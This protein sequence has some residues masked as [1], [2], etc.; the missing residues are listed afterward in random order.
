M[1]IINWKAIKEVT[2]KWRHILCSWMGTYKSY[3]QT[4]FY[5]PSLYCILHFHQRG[6]KDPPPASERPAET[7]G[8]SYHCLAIKVFFKVRYVLFFL[9]TV[10]LALT[11]VR[12]RYSFYV[13]WETERS[14]WPPR[15]PRYRSGRGLDRHCLSSACLSRRSVVPCQNPSETLW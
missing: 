15:C 11:R 6:G 14:L 2:N 7:S 12:R 4:L 8:D 5:F 3:R 1:K 13:R 10:P 9:D